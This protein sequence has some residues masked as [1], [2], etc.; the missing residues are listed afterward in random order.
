MCKTVPREMLGLGLCPPCAVP[1][2]WAMEWPHPAEFGVPAVGKEVG[3]CPDQGRMAQ[4][5][6]GTKPCTLGTPQGLRAEEAPLGQQ[7]PVPTILT[8]S[9]LKGNI[10]PLT[11]Q[12]SCAVTV[13]AEGPCSVPPRPDRAPIVGAIFSSPVGA[14]GRGRTP[15]L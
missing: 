12:N 15:P 1:V 5:W 3:T 10:F 2:E 9:R 6:G 4:G 11:P 14:G 7:F 13:P 8:V